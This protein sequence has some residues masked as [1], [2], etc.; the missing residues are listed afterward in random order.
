MILVYICLSLV[1]AP[2]LCTFIRLE[3][4]CV[5]NLLD[6]D[7]LVCVCFCTEL[8]SKGDPSNH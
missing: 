7:Q 8:F 4:E 1:R 3:G 6:L 5:S 2:V